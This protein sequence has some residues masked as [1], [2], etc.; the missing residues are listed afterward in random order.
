MV[1]LGIMSVVCLCRE[2]TVG[3][4]LS[5]EQY[6]WKTL[7]THPSPRRPGHHLAICFARASFLGFVPTMG[8][9]PVAHNVA[10]DVWPPGVSVCP[11]SSGHV[12]WFR[13]FLFAKAN[14]VEFVYG[15]IFVLYV[16]HAFGWKA[17]VEYSCFANIV[18]AQ[19]LA[20]L[21]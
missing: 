17:L 5:W 13:I 19:L 9:L 4:G 21:P 11:S 14:Y 12:S 2:A 3:P 16:I 7:A 8:A 18:A 10:W 20:N 6:L 1:R 15:C